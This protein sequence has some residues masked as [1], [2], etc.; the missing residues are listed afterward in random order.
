M[1]FLYR[2]IAGIIAG[3]TGSLIL[4]AAYLITAA[5][6]QPIID[7]ATATAGEN[8]HPMF[9]FIFMVM[10]F[11]AIL[12]TNVAGA[13][14]MG[15]LVK[16]KY[17]RIGESISKI[18]FL[19]LMIFV[20]MIPLYFIIANISIQYLI[21]AVTVQVFLSAQASILTL[22]IVSNSRDAIVGIYSTTLAILLGG[23]V[24]FLIGRFSDTQMAFLFSIFPAA[25]IFMGLSHGLLEEIYGLISGDKEPVS[26]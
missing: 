6:I 19:N 8:I 1:K 17:S 14:L 25:W 7:P 22:E 2:I 12:A 20:L 15:F 11:I 10:V 21:Y 16:E 24:L 18:L 4:L 9:T 26:S 5:Y 13:W 3:I 23:G